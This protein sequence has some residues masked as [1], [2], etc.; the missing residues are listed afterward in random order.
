[1]ATEVE[2][3]TIANVDVDIDGT[4]TGDK[5]P[6][7]LTKAH[8]Q[9]QRSV[10]ATT[11]FSFSSEQHFTIIAER[12]DCYHCKEFLG[13]FHLLNQLLL[14]VETPQLVYVPFVTGLTVATSCNDDA[15]AASNGCSASS[16]SCHRADCH[17][18]SQTSHISADAAA[19]AN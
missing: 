18:L 2:F 4:M 15:C 10:F 17:Y 5:F 9:R 8:F 6:E 19:I 7:R 16:S 1:M 11:S 14:L 3:V 12:Y 13:C